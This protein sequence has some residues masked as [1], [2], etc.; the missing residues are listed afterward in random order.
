MHGLL[1]I[2]FHD[3][4][5]LGCF[6]HFINCSCWI[7]LQEQIARCFRYSILYRFKCFNP[8]ESLEY[9]LRLHK[10]LCTWRQICPLCCSTWK[11]ED[12]HS[13]FPA[14]DKVPKTSP[15]VGT[16]P[17]RPGGASWGS[18]SANCPCIGG[19]RGNLKFHPGKNSNYL[20]WQDEISD[21]SWWLIYATTMVLSDWIQI[22]WPSSRIV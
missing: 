5:L 2:L 22:G 13:V 11:S 18:L 1:Q 17:L 7:S 14:F 3:L 8:T 6:M 19:K 12:P 21:F 4:L 9:P 10:N 15:G 16:T 20:S